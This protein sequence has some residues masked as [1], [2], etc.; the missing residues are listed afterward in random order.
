MFIFIEYLKQFE[1]IVRGLQQWLNGKIG[2]SQENATVTKGGGAH[3]SVGRKHSTP[4]DRVSVHA[5]GPP[6]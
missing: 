2:T 6:Q 1:I 5:P 4:G 3:Q